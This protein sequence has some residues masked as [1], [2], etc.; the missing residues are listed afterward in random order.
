MFHMRSAL[1]SYF[2]IIFTFAKKSKILKKGYI[3]FIATGIIA[4]I[5]NWKTLKFRKNF[6][7]NEPFFECWATKSIF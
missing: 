4:N 2:M 6:N 7:K 3:G 1:Y 5:E